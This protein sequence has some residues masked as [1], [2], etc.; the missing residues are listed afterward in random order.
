MSVNA[1]GWEGTVNPKVCCMPSLLISQ[2][3]VKCILALGKDYLQEVIIYEKF[4]VNMPGKYSPT[5][6]R[7][8]SSYGYHFRKCC[9]PFRC[10]TTGAGSGCCKF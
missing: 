3:L 10:N 8:S 1:A 9:P 4:Y 6:P 5:S 2:G 7:L